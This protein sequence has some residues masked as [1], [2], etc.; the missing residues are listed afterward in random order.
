MDERYIRTV[1]SNKVYKQIVSDCYAKNQLQSEEI[2]T[3]SM[4]TGV[5]DSKTVRRDKTT[6]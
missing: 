6:R 2:I 3:L 1:Q 5:S 4:Q